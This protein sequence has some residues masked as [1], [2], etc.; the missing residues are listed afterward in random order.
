[1]KIWDS[2]YIFPSRNSRSILFLFL[3]PFL[4]YVATLFLPVPFSTSIVYPWICRFKPV[5]RDCCEQFIKCF[6]LWCWWPIN[7]KINLVFTC[8]IP[9]NLVSA[10]TYASFFFSVVPSS[11]E[12]SFLT[13]LSLYFSHHYTY[14]TLQIML[15]LS[16]WV[17]NSFTA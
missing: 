9:L 17:I 15:G 13:F 7:L 8:F 5:L 16:V 14:C 11:E 10:S 3:T 12:T 6:Y 2:V 4:T 1:M